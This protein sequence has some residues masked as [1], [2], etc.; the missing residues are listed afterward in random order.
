MLTIVRFLT[1]SNCKNT[2]NIRY[3]EDATFGNFA[4]IKKQVQDIAD[5]Y[6]GE[7]SFIFYY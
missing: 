2:K 5:V 7:A 1:Y 4:M 3:Y 6:D